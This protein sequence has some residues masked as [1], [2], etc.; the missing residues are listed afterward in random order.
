MESRTLKGKKKHHTLIGSREKKLVTKNMCPRRPDRC[1]R[2]VT[3]RIE[4][5]Q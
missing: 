1:G 2:P 4:N 3:E 5:W